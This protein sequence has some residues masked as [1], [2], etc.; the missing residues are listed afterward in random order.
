MEHRLDKLKSIT[1][2]DGSNMLNLISS[3]PEQC[4]GAYEIGKR[5]GIGPSGRKYDNIVFVGVGA[6]AMGADIIRIYL[7]NELKIPLLVSRNYTLPAFVNAN[8]LLFCASYSGNTE[9]TIYSF[10][11]GLKRGSDIITIGSGGRLKELSLK[12]GFRHVDVPP[13]FAPRTA[14]GYMSVTFLAILAGLN[15]IEDKEEEVKTLFAVLSDLRDKEIGVNI[16]SSENISKKLAAGL[17]DSYCVI[18]G[19]SDTTES[20][21][22][23][24]RGQ[25]AE[26]AKTLSS[27]HVFPEMTHNEIVGWRFPEELL[28]KIKVIILRDKNDHPRT[29]KRI[30]IAK[31][32]I[33]GSGAGVFEIERPFHDSLLSR[34]FSLIYI[35]DFVSFY[36]AVLNNVDPAP[37]GK[38]DYL[39]EELAKI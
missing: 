22:M 16:G 25:L 14:L 39:K 12:N 35:G 2:L 8:S 28:K 31:N 3:L 7:R 5:S 11:D 4:R 38:I 37:I 21:S 36:L 1:E 13:G 24:W 17:Y 23:R 15:F 18:Y 20:V 6:S 26:N 10:E 29:Q 27:N 33:K 19:T 34:L 32:I 30:E 9:E